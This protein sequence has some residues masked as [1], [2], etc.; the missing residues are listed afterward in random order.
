MAYSAGSSHDQ[1]CTATQ[2]HAGTRVF[3]EDSR[4]SALDKVSA[5]GY[6]DKVCAGLTADFFNLILVSV[7]KRIIFGNDASGF[8]LIHVELSLLFNVESGI[9]CFQLRQAG[10]MQKE[11]LSV[12]LRPPETSMVA[13]VI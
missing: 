7:M 10:R 9:I 1:I 8:D 6:N 12:M 3:I 11:G 13:A 4:F 5:H 2:C